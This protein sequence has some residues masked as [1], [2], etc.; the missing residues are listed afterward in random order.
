MPKNLLATGLTP[1]HFPVTRLVRQEAAPIVLLSPIHLLVL[2]LLLSTQLPFLETHTGLNVHGRFLLR[3][4]TTRAFIQPLAAYPLVTLVTLLYA[5]GPLNAWELRLLA[6]ILYLPR[7]LPPQQNVMEDLA[8]LTVHNRLL[9]APRVTDE[10]MKLERLLLAKQLSSGTST[11]PVVQQEIRGLLIQKTLGR[12]PDAI[13]A[14]TP[15]LHVQELEWLTVLCEIRT[16]GPVLPYLVTPLAYYALI[17]LSL[18][19]S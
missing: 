18:A 17:R 1:V 6:L 5:T 3:L 2:P 13:V 8:V 11:L 16:P 15:P 14:V 4:T 9:Q 12:L 7:Q 19:G 10:G